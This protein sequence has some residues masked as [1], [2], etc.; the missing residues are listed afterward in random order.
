MLKLIKQY[1]FMVKN[2]SVPTILTKYAL[3]KP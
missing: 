3:K 1:A 2:L